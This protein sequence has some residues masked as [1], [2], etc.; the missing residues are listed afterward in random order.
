MNCTAIR[1]EAAQGVDPWDLTIIVVQTLSLLFHLF[2]AY[3]VFKLARE[4]F[5]LYILVSKLIAAILLLLASLAQH[6]AVYVP[7]TKIIL[8]FLNYIVT[9][10]AIFSAISN[11]L[12]IIA[13]AANRAHAIQLIGKVWPFTTAQV[14]AT[15]DNGLRTSQTQNIKSVNVV[16]SNRR[17]AVQ[18]S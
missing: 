13:L 3:P 4:R 15:T 8:F 16:G 10:C 5:A 7:S 18:R 12:H 2:C 11:R 14:A 1:M 9:P 17:L 6:V